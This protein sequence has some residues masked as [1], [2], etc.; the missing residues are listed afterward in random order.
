MSQFE[1]ASNSVIRELIQVV[2]ARRKQET[3]TYDETI[4]SLIT[5]VVVLANQVIELQRVKQ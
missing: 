4:D 3:E 1:N 2:N 5:L